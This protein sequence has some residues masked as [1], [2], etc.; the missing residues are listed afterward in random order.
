MSHRRGAGSKGSALPKGRL[1]P[2]GAA[3]LEA[4]QGNGVTLVRNSCLMSPA[5]VKKS[6]SNYTICDGIGSPS[7][8]SRSPGRP[9]R[10]SN[11]DAEDTVVVECDDLDMSTEDSRCWQRAAPARADARAR[12]QACVGAAWP[13]D[14]LVGEHSLHLPFEGRQTLSRPDTSSS[15]HRPSSTTGAVRPA[16]SA[17]EARERPGS[18]IGQRPRSRAVDRS[19]PLSTTQ[20]RPR[21]SFAYSSQ[22]RDTEVP[23]RPSTSIGTRTLPVVELKK[24]SDAIPPRTPLRPVTP[25]GWIEQ[26]KWDKDFLR[27]VSAGDSLSMEATDSKETEAMDANKIE[28][29]DISIDAGPTR[30]AANMQRERRMPRWKEII[31]L[32][33]G[34]RVR[35]V[36]GGLEGATVIPKQ[37]FCARPVAVEYRPPPIIF[38]EAAK[39]LKHVKGE[40]A[41]QRIWVEKAG[42]EAFAGSMSLMMA[43]RA[44][45]FSQLV[46]ARKAQEDQ[47]FIKAL[48]HEEGREEPLNRN[49]EAWITGL[50]SLMDKRVRLRRLQDTLAKAQEQH[51]E[52]LFTIKTT[53]N[54]LQAAADGDRAQIAARLQ[55]ALNRAAETEIEIVETRTLCEFFTISV[56]ELGSLQPAE[57]NE[58]GDVREWEQ[59]SEQLQNGVFKD[60]ASE[61]FCFVRAQNVLDN[62]RRGWWVEG[63]SSPNQQYDLSKHELQALADEGSSDLMG[64]VQRAES[65]DSE[66]DSG[67]VS[68][69]AVLRQKIEL[70]GKLLEKQKEWAR[71][72]QETPVW[73]R[74]SDYE[75]RRLADLSQCR[76]LYTVFYRLLSIF[77]FS[78]PVVVNVLGN[79]C[80]KR[81]IMLLV[82]LP[83]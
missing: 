31:G 15:Q 30:A 28:P 50:N 78:F 80:K 7:V 79:C 58:T 48:L 8:R 34:D 65:R 41:G 49:A 59:L 51:S 23:K 29:P 40:R 3:W 71:R 33:Q 53:Q 21:S 67:L 60:A 22:D 63:P 69:A 9:E 6:Y 64:D 74:S 76:T 44:K 52:A 38:T 17:S 66:D 46:I 68:E 54:L 24:K 82:V 1:A 36:H 47:E 25:C 26:K 81:C 77:T 14:E 39:R 32:R 61:S 12:A 55:E 42:R 19:R 13:D 70:R 45:K 73:Q 35:T 75:E 37:D 2:G 43:E 16:R 57:K 62:N 56:E 4:R 20:S 11:L 18:Q 5:G 27:F 83:S 72:D 10:E